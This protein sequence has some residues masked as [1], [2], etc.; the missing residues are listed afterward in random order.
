MAVV[1]WYNNRFDKILASE[2]IA[3]LNCEMSETEA[4]LAEPAAELVRAESG[5]ELAMA[6]GLQSAGFTR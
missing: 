5:S 2:G 6:I 4:V 3:A 1:N